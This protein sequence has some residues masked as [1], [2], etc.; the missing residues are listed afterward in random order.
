MSGVAGMPLPDAERAA[1]LRT[2]HTQA[3]AYRLMGRPVPARVALLDREYDWWRKRVQRGG[4]AAAAPRC[5]KP[6][7]RNE[8]GGPV[9]SDP[10][11]GRP[12]GHGGTC[13]SEGAWRRKLDANARYMQ[14]WRERS[15]AA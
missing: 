13:L 14:A 12:E 10:V 1:R 9:L 3:K 6:V 2:A 8:R 11:C 5:G 7:R 15:R 4:L